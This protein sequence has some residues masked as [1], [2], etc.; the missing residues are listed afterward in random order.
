[1]VPAIEHEGS[2]IWEAS[3]ITLYLADLFG[4]SAKLWPQSGPK[5]G[6]AMMWITW[7]HVT[8]QAAIVRVVAQLPESPVAEHMPVFVPK[9][10]RTEAALMRASQA[11]ADKF[12]VLNGGLEGRAYLCG[13]EYT[14]ADT[15]VG[16]LLGWCQKMGTDLSAYR[17][18][19]AWVD[20]CMSRPAIQ[21]VFSS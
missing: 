18:I 2:F 14:L 15:H 8:L 16:T 4:T 13:T 5:R 21:K 11:Q 6:E 3:A 9:D 17:N 7:A 10:E 12:G 20:R 1:M 19:G